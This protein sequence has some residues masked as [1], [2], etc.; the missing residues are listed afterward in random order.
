MQEICER[1][2]EPMAEQPAVFV[3]E[4]TPGVP[5][6]SVLFF[7]EWFLCPKG[8]AKGHPGG[9]APMPEAPQRIEP[10]SGGSLGHPD[11]I[12]WTEKGI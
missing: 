5:Q 1:C 2:N 10:P 12:V 8:H 9:N 7:D 4:Q 3:P 11:P 6:P